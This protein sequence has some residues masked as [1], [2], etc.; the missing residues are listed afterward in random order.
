M[1]VDASA[2]CASDLSVPETISN[3]PP[4]PVDFI[5]SNTFAADPVILASHIIFF[6]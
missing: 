3:S 5:F 4:V 1:S 6:P 2:E